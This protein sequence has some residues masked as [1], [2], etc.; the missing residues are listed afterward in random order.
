VV[1]LL[2]MQRPPSSP[3]ASPPRKTPPQKAPS[4]RPSARSRQ[5]RGGRQ[6]SQQRNQNPR[7]GQLKSQQR[8]VKRRPRPGMGGRSGGGDR[9]AYPPAGVARSGFF[10][11]RFDW[12]DASDNVSAGCKVPLSFDKQQYICWSR[13]LRTKREN[14]RGLGLE[15]QHLP[16]AAPFGIQSQ[17]ACKPLLH[18]AGLC[19]FWLTEATARAGRLPSTGQSTHERRFGRR[20]PA[21]N[22]SPAAVTG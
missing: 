4:S 5:Q 22:L 2:V 10:I 8:N 14:R 18:C 6:R 15:S 13:L 9:P 11:Y 20:Q 7:E 3:R 17:S 16:L 19:F 21:T 12:S 1:S